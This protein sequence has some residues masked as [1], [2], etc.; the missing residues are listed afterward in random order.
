MKRH[1][2][3]FKSIISRKF[4]FFCFFFVIGKSSVFF[5]PLLLSNIASSEVYGQVEYALAIAAILAILLNV[6]TTGSYPFFIVKKA[7][8]NFKKYY[9]LFPLS[10]LLVSFLNLLLFVNDVDH[11]YVL[12]IIIASNLALQTLASIIYKSKSKPVQAVLIESGVFVVLMLANLYFIKFNVNIIKSL[13][14]FNYGYALLIQAYFIRKLFAYQIIGNLS[15]S[16]LEVKSILS[17]GS[18][19]IVSSFLLTFL[20]VSGRI[21]V[22]YFSEDQL[23]LYAFYFRIASIV[24]IFHQVI[25]IFFFKKIYTSEPKTLDNY[26]TAFLIIIS[27]MSWLG[28]FISPY[29]LP[30]F[31]DLYAANGNN[32]FLLHSLLNFQMLFWAAVALNENIL[33]R[34]NLIAGANISLVIILVILLATLVVL[35]QFG[36]LDVFS[37]TL[38]HSLSIFAFYIFQNFI[39]IRKKRVIFAKTKFFLI[40]NAFLTVVIYIHCTY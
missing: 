35:N 11:T 21:I 16:F 7:N 38:I 8:D 4:A 15:W 9:Y 18:K 23:P 12:S 19:V 36:F 13:I 40:I 20:T 31:F 30:N 3:Q 10:H 27:V 32:Y 22:E 24:I 33:N 39:L 25:N 2:N 5:A 28:Y 1:L 34:E 6:G 37:I 14:L 29:I 26:F 17:F